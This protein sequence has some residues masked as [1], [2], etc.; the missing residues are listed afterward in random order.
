MIILSWNCQGLGNL[1]IVRDLHQMV[2][3]KRPHLVFLMETKMTQRKAEVVRIKLGFD[4]CFTVDC[5]GKSGGLMMLWRNTILVEIQNFSRQHI[6]AVVQCNSDAPR[7]KITGFY[8]HPD[9]AKR[10]ESWELLRYLARLSPEPWLCLG[11][12]NEITTASEKSSR[13]A[14]PCSQMRAFQ[15]ALADCRLMDMDYA[16]PKFTRCNGR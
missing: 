4:N 7:W 14:R 15:Q 2:R 6:N 5:I 16:G 1:R 12:F 10:G 13:S 3:D 9:V 8:W 11:D